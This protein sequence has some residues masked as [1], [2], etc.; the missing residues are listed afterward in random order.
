M[1]IRSENNIT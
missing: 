1:A